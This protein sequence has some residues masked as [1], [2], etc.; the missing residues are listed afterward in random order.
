M[1]ASAATPWLADRL[2]GAP[3]G[4]RVLATGPQAVYVDD[5]GVAVAVLAR[6][7]VAVPV[8][9]RT[10]L[11]RLPETA[12]AVVGDGRIG[13][14]HVVVEVTRL[15]TAEVPHLPRLAASGELLARW[16]RPG[17]DQRLDAVRAELPAPALRL[18]GA[19]DPGAVDA[20]LGLGSGLT[21]LGDD[22]LAGWLVARRA[23]GLPHDTVATAVAA[24]LPAASTRTTTLS[25]TLLH[26]AAAGESV[27]QL[28]RLLVAAASGRAPARVRSL[29]HDLL[30]VGHTSGAGLATGAA[31]AVPTGRTP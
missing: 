3:R 13:L 18:L 31:L 11:D 6:G 16:L 20:L 17:T 9:L 2:S 15:V 28:R 12:H 26:R 14:G 22:V 1:T 7:A 4:A 30:S 25:A 21:P 5:D 24:A 23:A 10:Q 27:P 8:G 29:L 19:G